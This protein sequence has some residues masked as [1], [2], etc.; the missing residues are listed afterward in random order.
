LFHQSAEKASTP[1]MQESQMS[2]DPVSGFIIVAL[3][4]CAC[5][6]Q[7]YLTAT[8]WLPQGALASRRD[9][10]LAY[11]G[12]VTHLVPSFL[13]PNSQII[14][15]VKPQSRL[16]RVAPLEAVNQISFSSF[17]VRKHSKTFFFMLQMQHQMQ[18]L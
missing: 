10:Q 16:L 17:R 1:K 2:A 4:L 15:P 3:M 5:S 18:N 8:V 14:F 11:R 6:P 9:V 12:L 13:T 7:S